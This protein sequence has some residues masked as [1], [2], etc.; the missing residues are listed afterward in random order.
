VKPG[1]PGPPADRHTAVAD[2]GDQ[3]REAN[4]R[5]WGS[6]PGVPRKDGPR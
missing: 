6:L 1:D 2:R 4:M 5:A 3:L